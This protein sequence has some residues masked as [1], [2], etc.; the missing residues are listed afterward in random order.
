MS[1]AEAQPSAPVTPPADAGKTTVVT[2]QTPPAAPAVPEAKPDA[3][4]KVET[5]TE[6]TPSTEQKPVVPEK[7]DLKLPKDALLDPSSVEMIAAIARERGLSNEQAQGLLEQQ[8]KSVADHI[9]QKSTAWMSQAQ[10]DKEIGGEAF[11]ENVELAKRVV[12]RF[13]TDTLK[14]ELSRFGY[15]NHP[16]LVRL[17]TRIGKTMANDQLIIPGS[18]SGGAKKIE[19]VFY[20]SKK[21]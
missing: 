3:S 4:V 14:Q 17:L 8:E 11:K 12:E 2:E 13:G 16:E 10:A 21:E 6:T 20:P 9:E 15:G 19:D 18:Q 1:V 7:Y 5:K